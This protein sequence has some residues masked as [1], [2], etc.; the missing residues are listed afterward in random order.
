MKRILISIIALTCAITGFAQVNSFTGDGYYRVQNNGSK[1]WA[2][3][4]D[5]TGSI[6]ISAAQTDIHSLWMIPNSDKI[7]YDPGTVIYI[8]KVGNNYDLYAQ[9]V[10]TH[11]FLEGHNFTLGQKG[12][13]GDAM[14]YQVYAQAGSS[15]IYL[16]DS[17]EAKNNSNP[18]GSNGFEHWNA[19]TKSSGDAAMNRWIVSPID[20]NTKN[21]IGIKPTISNNGEYYAP[22]YVSFPFKFVNKEMKA[23]Y[24]SKIDNK[25][26]IAV[27]KEIKEEVIPAATPIIVKCVSDNPVDNKIELLFNSGTAI[28]DN[29]LDGVYFC[30]HF[31]YEGESKDARTKFDESTMRILNVKDNKLVFSND[32][33]YLIKRSWQSSKESYYF[34]VDTNKYLNA[35]QSFL[36]VASG[37]AASL[38]VMTEAEYEETYNKTLP[39]DANGDN[40]IDIADVTMILKKMSGSAPAGYQEMNADV[41]G[42]GKIDIADVTATLRL[43]AK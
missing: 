15:T 35:N 23:Y 37:T 8:K 20:N 17:Y 10:W 33:E 14:I 7:Y 39:G 31:V 13:S 11:Q 6:S 22:Y 19:I 34:G 43:M 16:F 38:A 29:L 1:N 40:K 42:D 9:G 26:N 21:F 18:I 32:S 28:N 3:V 5:N 25:N 4:S 2:K 41:N 30:N 36:N 12:I 24:V 27:I